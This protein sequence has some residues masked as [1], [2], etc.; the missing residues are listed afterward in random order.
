MRTAPETKTERA[1]EE[2]ALV[3]R[4]QD[5]RQVPVV[6]LLAE[7]GVDRFVS[8]LESWGIASLDT[9]LGFYGLSAAI[10]GIE[11]TPL[12]LAGLYAMLA[13]DGRSASRRIRVR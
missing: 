3:D 2:V 9:R 11:L 5:A 13:R 1:L 8:R 12:E 6:N 7:I 10:G 4:A